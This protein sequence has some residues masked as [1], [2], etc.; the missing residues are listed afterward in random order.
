MNLN[1]E[2]GP[3]SDQVCLA[4]FG[5]LQMEFWAL[6]ERIG[7]TTYAELAE[8]IIRHLD[9]AYPGKVGLDAQQPDMPFVSNPR[10]TQ[11]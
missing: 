1:Q 3:G 4:E 7:N 8:G 9:S 5:S 6:S 11:C 2:Q 10:N